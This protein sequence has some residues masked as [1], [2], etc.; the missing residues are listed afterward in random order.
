MT[1]EWFWPEGFYALAMIA[2][3][4]FGAFAL[5]LPIAIAMSA[6]AVVGALRILWDIVQAVS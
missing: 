6:A 1:M 5:K 2:A 4:A 3:F